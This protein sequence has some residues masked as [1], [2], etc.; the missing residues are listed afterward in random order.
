MNASRT[1]CPLL[2][3]LVGCAAGCVLPVPVVTHPRA[4]VVVPDLAPDGRAVVIP[5]LLWLG[6]EG[7]NSYEILPACTVSAAFDGMVQYPHRLHFN[8]IVLFMLAADF[9][10]YPGL[11]AFADRKVP[12]DISL[13]SKTNSSIDFGEMRGAR[14]PNSSMDF[15]EMERARDFYVFRL[16]F[17][18]GDK[19]PQQAVNESAPWWP[20]VDKVI[21]SVVSS[22]DITKAE[23]QMVLEQLLALA[24]KWQ[25]CPCPADDGGPP[26]PP[27]PPAPEVIRCIEQ[28]LA[29]LE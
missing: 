8:V 6:G 16:S 25:A 10:P 20:S 23:K 29:G 1:A 19:D 14:A 2:L 21:Q 26:P 27:P 13:R 11:L 15:K 22:G 28:A 18:S 9:R 17:R 12:T 24:R 3:A 5:Y 7:K 4:E